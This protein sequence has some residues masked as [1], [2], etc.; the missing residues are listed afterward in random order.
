MLTL[1]A[2]KCQREKFRCHNLIKFYA[3]LAAL[4]RSRYDIRFLRFFFVMFHRAHSTKLAAA[5]SREISHDAAALL[6]VPLSHLL[7][8]GK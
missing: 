7:A 3:L 8:D 5:A 4:T 2:N 6:P 1:V